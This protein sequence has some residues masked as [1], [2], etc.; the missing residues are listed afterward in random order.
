MLLWIFIIFH[1]TE[2]EHQHLFEGYAHLKFGLTVF[3]HQPTDVRKYY[4]IKAV[5]GRILNYSVWFFLVS[6]P[7]SIVINRNCCFLY[8]LSSCR[9]K[10]KYSS[11]PVTVL[12]ILVTIEVPS[13]ADVLDIKCKSHTFKHAYIHITTTNYNIQNMYL[14]TFPCIHTSMMAPSGSLRKWRYN[15]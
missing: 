7:P 4:L 1:Q 6:P 9:Q 5:A 10:L 13:G 15:S 11:K 14:Q 8:V 12:Q 3:F 2:M